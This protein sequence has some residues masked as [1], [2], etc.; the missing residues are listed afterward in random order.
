LVLGDGVAQAYFS[1]SGASASTGRH[2]LTC[3]LA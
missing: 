3:L 2:L 1:N